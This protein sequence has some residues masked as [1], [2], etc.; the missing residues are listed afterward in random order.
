MTTNIDIPSLLASADRRT[1]AA[2]VTHLAGNPKAVPDLRDRAR[3]EALAAQLLPSYLTGEKIAGPPSDEVL[4]AAMNL[5]AGEKVPA[6]YGPMVREQMGIGPAIAPQPLNPPADFHVVIIGDGVSGVLAG[7][8][9]DQMGLS[10]FTLLEKNPEPGGTWWQNSYPGCRVD[11][12]VSC[13]HIRLPQ[14]AGGRTFSHQPDLLNYVKDI[15][16]TH[17]FGDRLQCNTSLKR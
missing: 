12:Q 11:T 13:I 2:V 16:A 10:S 7:L 5:A 15:V 3:I 9:L 8:T 17:N 14:I 4:Q 6:E 1:L